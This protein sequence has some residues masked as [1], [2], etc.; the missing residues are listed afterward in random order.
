M[1]PGFIE[2][3]GLKGQIDLPANLE[4][5]RVREPIS[6]HQLACWS[7]LRTLRT[8]KHHPERIEQHELGMTLDGRGHVL[9]LRA[10]GEAREFFDLTA[11][12]R[13]EERGLR[14]EF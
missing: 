4:S 5:L 1:G 3:L 2:A 11:H 14:I 8:R 13:I 7:D 9:P 6:Y 12:F 10:R